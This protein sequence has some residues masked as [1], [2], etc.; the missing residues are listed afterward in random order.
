MEDHPLLTPAK[1]PY[2]PTPSP[3][4]A[5][6]VGLLVGTGIGAAI[7]YGWVIV[8]LALIVGGVWTGKGIY[9]RT[10]R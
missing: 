2:Q 3:W 6:L 9:G 8:G 1:P 7:L 10:T 4:W 5:A